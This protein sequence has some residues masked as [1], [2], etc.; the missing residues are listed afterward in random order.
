METIHIVE[1]DYI[2]TT[3]SDCIIPSELEAKQH[4]DCNFDALK[5]GILKTE[6]HGDILCWIAF[7]KNKPNQIL[8]AFFCDKN[9]PP[10]EGNAQFSEF[11][12]ESYFKYNNK[13]YIFKKDK[14]LD[15]AIFE[16]TMLDRKSDV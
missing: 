16:I 12:D 6:E 1:N 3:S 14:I 5:F 11:S 7:Y 8:K 9:L 13:F 10:V 2:K 4:V 15:F